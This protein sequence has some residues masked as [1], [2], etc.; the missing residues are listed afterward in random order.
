MKEKLT[1]S[2]KRDKRIHEGKSHLTEISYDT[3]NETSAQTIETD[4]H[5][6][7]LISDLFRVNR[8]FNLFKMS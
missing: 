7:T 3:H 8:I 6:D 5:S 1:P 2:H 4:Y